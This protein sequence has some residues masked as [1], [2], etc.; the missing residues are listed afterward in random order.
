MIATVEHRF[1]DGRILGKPFAFL[2][3]VGDLKSG[4][5]SH[6]AAR[7][8]PLAEEQP[9]ERSLADPVGADDPDAV[10]TLDQAGKFLH[11]R[12]ARIAEGDPRRFDRPSPG[13]FA[14]GV[15][16]L[17]VGTVG[18]IPARRTV[19][20]HVAEPADPAHVAGAP[21][22][23]TAANPRLLGRETVVEPF[24]LEILRRPTFI[25]PAQEI[26]VVARPRR[27]EAAVDLDDAVRDPAQECPVVGGEHETSPVARDRSLEPFDG[28]EIEVIRRLVEE[29]ETRLPDHGPGQQ[30]PSF[31]PARQ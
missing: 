27:H 28:G 3:E 14:F 7:R 30:D 8:L 4:S 17:E 25:P 26:V 22:S 13:T 19:P 2:V 18:T 24:R 5:V 10:A 11:E 29:E 20:P 16:D 12:R 15:P 1:G 23:G 6:F 31:L 9:N 21:R